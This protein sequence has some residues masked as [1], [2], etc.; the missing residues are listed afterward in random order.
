M[1]KINNKLISLIE[2]L[3]SEEIKQL[4]K[5]ISSPF[6]TNGRNYNPFL[7]EVIKFS[8]NPGK[9]NN[10][11]YIK[12]SEIPGNLNDQT[13]RNRYSELY[14]L[15]EEFLIYKSNKKKFSD[16]NK[17]LMA[18]LLER[19]LYSS[20]KYNHIETIKQL[21]KE[22][23][24]IEKYKSLS[25]FSTLNETFLHQIKKHELYYNELHKNSKTIICLNLLSLLD[26]GLEFLHQEF[27]D[28]KFEPNYVYTFLKLLNIDEI[29]DK[30]KNSDS[31]IERVTSMNY[32]IYKAFENKE[33]E[34][35]YFESHK[36][37]TGL[38][39]ELKDSY[40]VRTY[41]HFINYCII[42]QNNGIAKFQHELFKLYNE[43][44]EQ[45][46]IS[47]F[48]INLY[49]FN[50]FRD[51]VFIGISL[52]EFRWVEDFIK[53]YSSVLPDEIRESET[54]ISYANLYFALGEFS[55]SL[56]YM[57]FHKSSHF[58]SYFDS[59]ILKLC[60]FYELMKYEDA[61]LE[62]D[63]LK[64]YLKNN[65]KT[66]DNYKENVSNFIKIYQKLLK[67]RTN[68]GKSDTGL[69][70]KELKKFKNIANPFWLNEKLSE[71]EK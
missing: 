19:K 28:I 14:K 30:F 8:A 27:Y 40:K 61:F 41:N 58:M 66:P 1:I 64:H 7:N 11:K 18:E 67:L 57:E 31:V 63:N 69:I 47:D 12:K 16:R 45:S 3:N 33:N 43:K 2:S 26:L 39:S 60:N 37:F 42:K 24:S 25:E 17:I 13:L 35:F 55:K 46:L 15:C 49:L 20:F 32:N 50:S 44:L 36:I 6:F 22:K 4:K 53:K 56:S 59:S 29:I 70:K 54:N 5:F 52:K 51:Y 21:N 38:I 71:L 48:K 68:Y 65:I 23:F 62:L 10:Y 34:N 9:K